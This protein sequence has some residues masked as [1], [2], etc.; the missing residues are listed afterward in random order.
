MRA[1]LLK[2]P[3]PWRTHPSLIVDLNQQHNAS[4]QLRSAQKFSK[5]LQFGEAARARSEISW[6]KSGR[7]FSFRTGQVGGRVTKIFEFGSNSGQNLVKKCWFKPYYICTIFLL[8]Y[9]FHF[10]AHCEIEL[11]HLAVSGGPELNFSWLGW[12]IFS[13]LVSFWKMEG[14]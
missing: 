10:L 7:V 4:S 1:P 6:V 12:S 13:Y 8:H 14:N 11:P 3:P 9:I 5:N 2:G